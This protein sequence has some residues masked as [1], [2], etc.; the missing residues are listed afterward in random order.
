MF[1]LKSMKLKL[2][3]ILLLISGFAHANNPT[4]S[5]INTFKS[6]D[7]QTITK[8]LTDNKGNVYTV[9]TFRTSL[10][11]GNYTIY[12]YGIQNIYIVKYDSS[13]K[14]L[15]AKNDCTGE[16]GLNLNSAAI[17]KSGNII[18][19][20]DFYS[21]QKSFGSIVLSNSNPSGPTKYF[22]VKYNSD[23]NVLWAKSNSTTISYTI[24]D[25]V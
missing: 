9:G 2:L 5:W 23:G 15:W 8:T 25:V 11:F 3:F 4:P 14:F 22:V 19:C 17:D 16:G 7:N 24:G 18:L 13:G 1:P 21:N 12:S 10:T 6:Y 20:G